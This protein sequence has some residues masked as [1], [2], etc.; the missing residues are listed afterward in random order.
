MA[1]VNFY[2]CKGPGSSKAIMRHSE[3]EERLKHEHSNPDINKSCT[4]KNTSRYGLS[5]DD[6]CKKYDDW[7]KFL[8]ETTNTNKRS[9]RVTM[10]SLEYSVPEDLPEWLE[11][12][13]I[14][15]VEKVIAEQ[16]GEHN[17]IESERHFDEKHVYIDHGEEKMSRAHGHTF[18]IPEVDGQL[19]G[20]R[21]SSK[22]QMMKLN[23]AIDNMSRKK[24]HV[25]F[26]T[27]KEA[28]KKSV[29]ELKHDSLIEKQELTIQKNSE[30]LERQ[31]ETNKALKVEKS[32]LKEELAKLKED[33]GQEK[34]NLEL[35]F[36]AEQ[37]RLE[38]NYAKR[39]KELAE[40]ELKLSKREERLSGRELSLDELRELKNKT[41]WSS[42]DKEN[43]LKTA[44]LSARNAQKADNAI[45]DKN[46]A[47][48]KINKLNEAITS[49][50]AQVPSH[51]EMIHYRAQDDRIAVLE[52]S[53]KDLKAESR[54]KSEFIDKN[55]LTKALKEH[56]ADIG[57]KLIVSMP[58]KVYEM[59]R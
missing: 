2:K 59:I 35:Q 56:C 57:H 18:V 13:W 49:L 53:V 16:Y 7:I 46:I 55:G 4:E 11:D 38:E 40:K 48:K 37:A 23:K 39:K 42:E 8:D 44:K 31:V 54:I 6:M 28:R 10:F 47:S 19:N 34:S 1:S 3:K 30:V 24:Y 36:Q 50:K 15:D 33:F 20:K 22:S 9:D 25:A 43:V 21:F 51:D 58:N 32:D 45:L 14:E 27:G 26:M 5:Y 12:S 41:F 17:I 52:Q 29:E